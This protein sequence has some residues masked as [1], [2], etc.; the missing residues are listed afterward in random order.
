MNAP[1]LQVELEA[2]IIIA[3]HISDSDSGH[4]S[5]WHWQILSSLPVQVP[6]TASGT[7]KF[8]IPLVVIVLVVVVE[9]VV[10]RSNQGRQPLTLDLCIATRE[11]PLH[12]I[13]V[14]YTLSRLQFKLNNLKVKLDSKDN[15]HAYHFNVNC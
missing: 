6:D 13:C 9:V 5:H 14:G 15:C 1:E 7:G 10:P 8:K 11:I 3:A 2:S 4:A 12:M